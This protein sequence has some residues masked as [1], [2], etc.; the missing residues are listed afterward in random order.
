MRGTPVALATFCSLS[1]GAWVGFYL[2]AALIAWEVST[3]R[4]SRRWML[5]GLS[6]VL[7]YIIVDII[8]NRPP[9]LVF[10]DY[11]TF[12]QGNSYNRVLIWEFGSASV[13]KHPLMGIGRGDWERASWMSASMDNF[14]LVLVVR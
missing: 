2:Q 10:I 3:R 12:S 7:V 4:L 5:L 9:I 6:F 13:W 14:W 1:V 11:L 8:S